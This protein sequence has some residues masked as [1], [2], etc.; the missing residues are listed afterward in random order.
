M[1]GTKRRTKRAFTS[2]LY[3]CPLFASFHCIVPD[4]LYPCPLLMVGVMAVDQRRLEMYRDDRGKRIM[5]KVLC[6]LN[7]HDAFVTF[8]N[9]GCEGNNNLQDSLH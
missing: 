9:I 5:E 6:Q 3:L 8:I 2:F 7:P 1:K 4:F